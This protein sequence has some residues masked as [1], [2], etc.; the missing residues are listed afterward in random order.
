MAAADL[1]AAPPWFR[2][3]ERRL[4]PLATAAVI[5]SALTGAGILLGAIDP[6]FAPGGAPHPTLHGSAGEALSILAA[7]LRVLAP[8]F[9]LAAFGV[10]HSRSGRRFG[11][12]LIATVVMLNTLH[13]GLAIGHFGIRL[14]PYLPHLPLESLAL[15]LSLASWL[16]LRTPPVSRRTVARNAL[17]VLAVTTAAA[18]SETLLTPHLPDRRAAGRQGGNGLTGRARLAPSGRSWAGF[19]AP[20]SCTGGG[21]VASRS[22]TLS[23]PCSAR[24]RSAVWPVPIRAH[25]PPT[26]PTRRD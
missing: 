4:S 25:Q 17:I 11:D 12:L 21:L 13:V 19:L 5:V 6:A 23:S 3:G 14:L 26:I 15:A 20:G 7:N 8:P 1:T 9:V 10:H 2:D 24:F 18:G 16:E 22:L